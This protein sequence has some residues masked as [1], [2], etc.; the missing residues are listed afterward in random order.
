MKNILS[1]NML[2]FGVKNLSESNKKKLTL[3][4][5]LQTINE[6]GLTEDIKRLL[7]EQQSIQIRGCMPFTGAMGDDASIASAFGKAWNYPRANPA[8]WV[9]TQ[10]ASRVN[11][12]GQGGMLELDFVDL[13]FKAS[14]NV[15]KQGGQKGLGF[16]K[17][18]PGFIYDPA[19]FINVTEV[20][21]DD[22]KDNAKFAPYIAKEWNSGAFSQNW[23]GALA[24]YGG[25]EQ[26]KGFAG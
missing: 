14:Y 4:S 20:V 3:E 13:G 17:C 7:N 15:N 25:H 11:I 2:R 22:S 19:K 18:E 23:K 24:I 1:E 12:S 5:I 6:H 21:N 9:N 8:S 26:L 16:A 10:S